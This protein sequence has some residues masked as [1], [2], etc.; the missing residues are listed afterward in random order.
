MSKGRQYLVSTDGTNT[1]FD[2][3]TGKYYTI[4]D[5]E[6]LHSNTDRRYQSSN[7]GQCCGLDLVSARY[8]DQIRHYNGRQRSKRPPA[9]FLHQQSSK[10]EQL[11]ML[12]R[13][14][15]HQQQDT[16]W[17][18][19]SSS[20]IPSHEEQTDISNTVQKNSVMAESPSTEQS[21]TPR[22]P[23]Q[24]QALIKDVRNDES[25][26][27]QYSQQDSTAT[28]N[29]STQNDS[30]DFITV[31]SKKSEKKEQQKQKKQASQIQQD[32]SKLNTE[33]NKNTKN[34]NVEYIIS[35]NS[36][37]RNQ[38]NMRIIPSSSHNIQQQTTSGG[39]QLPITKY[40]LEYASN[41]HFAPFK[42]ECQPKIRNRKDGTKLINELIKSITSD[43]LIQNPRFSHEILFDLWWIDADGNI[44]IIIKTTDLYVY[45]CKRDRYPNQLNNVKINPIPP[46]HLPPQHT[47]IIKWVNNSFTDDD[48][49][50]EL[51]MKFESLFSIE[52]MHGTINERN[53][54]IK[55]ELLD[56]NEYDK[57]LNSGKINLGGQLYSVDEYLPSPRILM[58]NRCNFPGHTKKLCRNSDVDLCRRCGKPRT[59]IQEHKECE[60]K[61][62]HCQENHL[63]T[64]YK[65]K[66]IDNYRRE[67]IDELKRHP[68]RMPPEVQL[69]IPTEYRSE[70]RRK[71][72]YNEEA[73]YQNQ[74]VQQQQFFN[75][76]DV[77]AWPGLRTTSV[78]TTTAAVSNNL[79]ETVKTLSDELK[80]IKMRHEIVQKQIE[81]KYKASIEMINQTW[82]LFKPVQQTQEMMI[83][84]MS[85]VLN[86][87]MFPLC[88]KS[89]EI[90]QSVIT[91]LKLR[92]R[93]IEL[94]DVT[95]LI[96]NQIS[97]INE[98]HKEF[99]RH[100]EELITISSKQNETM[101]MAMDTLFQHINE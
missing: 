87:A 63:A 29:E 17:Q 55:V 12:Y 35:N 51:N 38:H 82:L 95:E 44:Q 73:Y 16:T 8:G 21:N 20:N 62:H 30:D 1:L 15:T 3:A 84:S 36:V 89:S 4:V 52:S 85:K 14:Q 88:S 25:R 23:E 71:M 67:L 79:S 32:T 27:N 76:S 49:R 40:A 65:C 90:L 61:C 19:N 60:I 69:F 6:Y 91:K 39:N 48:V 37:N 41:Y 83:S 59:N 22:Q 81:E 13:Q 11:K 78:P 33:Y 45:L 42:L 101:D 47:G 64:D 50:D 53:R 31:G 5:D 99:D 70:D 66:I 86:Q 98:A 72:I 28:T 18:G 58:C 92:V 24:V 68:E 57:L 74:Y 93:N 80:E 56:K 34:T 26:M 54:H 75:K 97:Y 2:P 43:F 96:N 7:F 10:S 9:K 46:T 94:D 77:N 100:Q